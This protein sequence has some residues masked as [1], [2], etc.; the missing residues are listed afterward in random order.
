MRRTA[1]ALLT[2]LLALASCES[3][4]CTL[5]NIVTCNYAFYNSEG[6][7]VGVSDTLTVT[8]DGTDSILL[9]KEANVETFS[10]PMSYWRDEDTLN[11]SF[12][13]ASSD[14]VLRMVMYVGKTNHEYF[15]SPD[16]PTSMFHEL[17][18][19]YFETNTPFVDSVVV[20]NK[21]VNYDAQ[22]NVRIYLHTAD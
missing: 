6:E 5:N 22:E 4:D 13:S 16:C 1:Y 14:Y 8:A 17:K 3:I 15:E 18:S 10:I 7:A 20:V 2:S 11:L 21:A 9:N 19:L 12:K